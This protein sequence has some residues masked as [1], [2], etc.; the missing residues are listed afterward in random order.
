[1]IVIGAGIHGSAAT[2]QLAR[3]G[4]RVTQLDR[5]P[6]GHT[7]GSSHGHTRMIR[8]SYPS[9]FWDG[10]VDRAYTAWDA[11]SAAAG[12]PLVTRT[13]GLYARS[14]GDPGL[15][16]P[17]GRTVGF[18]EASLIFPGLRLAEGWTAHYDPEAGVIDAAAALTHLRKLAL[19]EGAQRRTGATVTSWQSDG[20]GVR[21]STGDG[22]LTADR[23]VVCAGPWTAE[24]L[25]QFA[26]LLTVQRIIT[27]NLGARDPELVGRPGLGAFSVAI[28]DVGLLFGIPAFH[29]DALKVGL[30]PGPGDDMSRAQWAPQPAEIERLA[31]LAAPFL[32]GVDGSVVDSVACRYT[33]APRNRFAIGELPGTPH[34]LVG[35]A[36]SGHGFKFGPAVGEALADLATG[37]ER[38][39]LD[40]HSPAAMGVTP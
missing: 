35:A 33:M 6:D 8:R 39:D 14:D 1:M 40:G 17:N 3:R 36:C 27:V 25:P 37:V 19:A 20:S 2:W 9:A 15:R 12:T 22:D 24:L 32:P 10:L 5:H 38:P 29:G 13:G 30:E 23:L 26:D 16:S 31:A 7:E 4:I 28:P 18:E 21:V 34:V 11:L